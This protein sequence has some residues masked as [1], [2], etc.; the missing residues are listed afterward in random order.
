MKA[1]SRLYEDFKIKFL[2]VLISNVNIFKLLGLTLICSF[3]IL[4]KDVLNK[5]NNQNIL[6]I[7]TVIV[8][9]RNADLMKKDIFENLIKLYIL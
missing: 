3:G 4:K 2:I 5:I 8:V 7:Y 6:T 9:N 1:L